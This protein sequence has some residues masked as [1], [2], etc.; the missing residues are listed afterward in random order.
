M[1]FNREEG[2]WEIWL[3]EHAIAGAT[4]TAKSRRQARLSPPDHSSHLGKPGARIA[5]PLERIQTTSYER[6]FFSRVGPGVATRASHRSGRARLTH[7][8]LRRRDSLGAQGPEV[9]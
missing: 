3:F 4:P 9:R 1:K 8:A 5:A 6:D 2:G 7:P